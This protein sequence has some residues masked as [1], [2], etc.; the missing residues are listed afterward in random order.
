[1]PAIKLNAIV[2]PAGYLIFCLSNPIKSLS[3]LFYFQYAGS[4]NV[5]EKFKLWHPEHFH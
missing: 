2:S 4:R 1:M 3:V 5:V